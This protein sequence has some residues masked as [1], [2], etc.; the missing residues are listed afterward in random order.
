MSPPC[1][2]ISAS[3]VSVRTRN[4]SWG[5]PAGADL[6]RRVPA[7]LAAGV[8]ER[9][10]VVLGVGTAPCADGPAGTGGRSS[11]C[12]ASQRSSREKENTK[13][14]IRRWVSM[15]E[16]DD[17]GTGSWPPGCQGWQRAKRVRASHTPRAAPW[18]SSASSAYA[19]Q[20]G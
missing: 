9:A 15:K 13:N 19:E 3:M 4:R 10:P 2:S 12:H 16:A 7:L 14:R 11:F 6:T 17:Y 5:L 20:E 8:P 1:V 18:R